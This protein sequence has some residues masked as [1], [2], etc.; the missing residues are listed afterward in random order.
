M[1]IDPLE[2]PARRRF[3]YWPRRRDP[4]ERGFSFCDERRWMSQSTGACRAKS[5]GPDD[6]RRRRGMRLVMTLPCND[7]SSVVR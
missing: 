6:G 5:P 7:A 3:R 2:K 1:V 4:V